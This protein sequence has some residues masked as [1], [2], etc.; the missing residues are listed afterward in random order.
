MNGRC[1]INMENVS[2]RYTIFVNQY[3]YDTPCWD[4]LITVCFSHASAGWIQLWIGGTSFLQHVTIYTTHVYDPY[5]EMIE[6]L[7]AVAENRLPARLAIDEEGVGKTLIALPLDDGR[8]DL[9]IQDT[10][11][12]EDGE[13]L[14]RMRVDRRQLVQEFVSKFELFIQSYYQEEQWEHGCALRTL[15]LSGLK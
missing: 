14:F 9:Q 2:S 12:E 3:P 15:D 11:E 1:L 7:Q 5:P 6:W 4:G 10:L 8:I 13:I